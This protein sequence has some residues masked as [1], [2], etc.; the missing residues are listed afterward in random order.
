MTLQ[1]RHTFTLQ[2]R[3]I[4]PCQTQLLQTETER[5]GVGERL[6]STHQQ[7][8][9][10]LVQLVRQRHPHLLELSCRGH[11]GAW[12]CNHVRTW[13]HGH[14]GM[15]A[16]QCAGC[17]CLSCATV[18]LRQRA[19]QPQPQRVRVQACGIGSARLATTDHPLALD[20][21]KQRWCFAEGRTPANERP[22]GLAWVGW[23]KPGQR[24]WSAATG[25]VLQE[26]HKKK[27]ACSH[28]CPTHLQ[29][30]KAGGFQLCCMSHCSSAPEHCL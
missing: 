14:K 18:G 4:R 28:H 21:P 16:A 8:G 17:P 1:A 12:R 5:E 30:G 6:N 2:Q 13:A 9:H 24:K 27:R 3:C 25:A 22:L 29:A 19:P 11:V 26:L 23:V 15:W 10:V 20:L 7:W